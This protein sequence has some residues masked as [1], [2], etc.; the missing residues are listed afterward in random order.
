MAMMHGLFSV[1]LLIPALLACTVLIVMLG[2]S[3]SRG[4]VART[5]WKHARLLLAVSAS[6]DFAITAP[7]ARFWATNSGEL[8]PMV[9]LTLSLDIYFFVYVIL[10]RRARDVFARFPTF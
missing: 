2:R 6:V 4:V 3:P 1:K 8:S 9:A 10:A 5:V 7:E